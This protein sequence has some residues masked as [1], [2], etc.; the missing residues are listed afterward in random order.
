MKHP[1]TKLLLYKLLSLAIKHH[2]HALHAQISIL[3]SLQYYEH[4]AEPMAELLGVLAKEFDYA[5]LGDEV[6][7]EVGGRVF[8]AADSRGPRSFS[9]FL[10]R[11]SEI[12]P[13]GV[14]KQLSLLLAHLDSEVR[15]LSFF[16]FYYIY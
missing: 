13:R 11:Y 4:L 1:P 15:F 10:V 8:G 2:S 5:Q 7:R 16:L 12:C 9:K 6:L 3:Q 14:L